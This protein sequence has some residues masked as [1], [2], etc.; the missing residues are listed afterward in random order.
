MHSGPPPESVAV[1]MGNYVDEFVSAIL[2]IPRGDQRDPPGDHWGTG[3]LVQEFDEP[4]LATC[5]HVARKQSQG[6]LGYSC[7]GCD[8]GISVGSKFDLHPFEIDFAKASISKTFRTVEHRGKC[9]I[10]AQYADFHS[11]VAEEYFYTYGFPGV[12]ARAGFGQHEAKGMGVFLREVDFDP[13]SFTQNPVPVL[14]THICLAWNPEN[15]SEL[16][17]TT[18]ELSLP[19]GMSGAPLWNTRYVE[20]TQRGDQWK[21]SDSKITGIVW[22]HSAKSG[23]L[24]ATPINL[25]IDLLFPRQVIPTC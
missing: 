21:P 23:H 6:T 1:A 22:G 18:G 25:F 2:L 13:A 16:L 17:G 12:D 9:T 19:N 20:V 4:I 11:P 14:G 3:W 8:L 15:A 24:F 7:H 5:E 10:K